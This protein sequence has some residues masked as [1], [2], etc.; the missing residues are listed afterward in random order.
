[1]SAAELSRAKRGTDFQKVADAPSLLPPSIV[2][3]PA[4][5]QLFLRIFADSSKFH[6][7]HV[8]HFALLI[9]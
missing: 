3:I 1:M 7:I 2:V 8:H 9:V 5:K 4:Q 6:Q